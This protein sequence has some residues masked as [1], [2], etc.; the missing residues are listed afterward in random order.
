M[1]L[2]L[3]PALFSFSAEESMDFVRGKRQS[4]EGTVSYVREILAPDNEVP[5][6]YI[7]ETRTL[8]E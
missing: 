8:T 3:I 5:P 7:L 1:W 4:S 6:D 2:S